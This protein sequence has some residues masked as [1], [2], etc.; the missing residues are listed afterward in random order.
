M[1]AYQSIVAW[2]LIGGVAGWLAGL[3]VEGYGF[4]VIGNIIV[5][6][7]GAGIAGLLAAMLGVYTHGLFGNILAATLGALILLFF[8][9]LLRRL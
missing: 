7:V 9:G 6:I 5:G 3:L 2:I 1:L 4:G 8:V